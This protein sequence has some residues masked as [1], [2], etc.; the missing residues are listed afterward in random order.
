MNFLYYLVGAGVTFIG[1]IVYRIFQNAGSY[2]LNQASIL[3][4]V[5][6][7]LIAG[8]AFLATDYVMFKKKN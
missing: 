3:E 5:I 2:T 4:T 1:I 7:A 8:A 6:I